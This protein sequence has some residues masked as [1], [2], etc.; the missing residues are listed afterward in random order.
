ML[1]PL[2]TPKLSHDVIK[3]D[4]H[5]AKATR[6]WGAGTRVDLAPQAALRKTRAQHDEFARQKV[7][8]QEKRTA[9]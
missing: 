1:I 3:A 8:L 4:L 6:I 9:N 7:K 5:L 2:T